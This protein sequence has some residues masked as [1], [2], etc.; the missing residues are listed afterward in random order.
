M[1]FIVPHE[2]KTN[3]FIRQNIKCEIIKESQ[4]QVN[5]II[6]H[7]HHSMLTTL[8]SCLPWVLRSGTDTIVVLLYH[9]DAAGKTCFS[10][11]KY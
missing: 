8:N 5:N 3:S 9:S 2:F 4:L 10:N 7:I 6:R 1:M 11:F